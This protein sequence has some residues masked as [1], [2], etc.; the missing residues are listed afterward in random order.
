MLNWTNWVMFYL[1]SEGNEQ[2]QQWRKFIFQQL[3]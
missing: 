2:A 1:M 3:K